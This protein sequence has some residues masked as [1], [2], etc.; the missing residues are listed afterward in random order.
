MNIITGPNFASPE[1]T[2]PLNRGVPKESW[3]HCVEKVPAL[4]WGAQA[5]ELKKYANNLELFGH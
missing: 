2:C 5:C 4:M 3:F 1:R